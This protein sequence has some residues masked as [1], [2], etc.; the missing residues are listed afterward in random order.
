MK[1]QSIKLSLLKGNSGQIN[2]LPKNPRVIKDDRFAAL[3]KSIQDTPEMLELRELIVFPFA[4]TFVVI[5]GNMRLR[6]L[7]EL[8]Y[9]EAPCKVLTAETPVETLRAI[10]IKDNVAFG[11][12]NFDD[13]ANEWDI[14]ELA[15]W[16]QELPVA[17]TEESEEEK[18]EQEGE[19]VIELTIIFR[20]LKAL[21]ELKKEL[22]ERGFDIKPNK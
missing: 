4:D 20:N 19:E 12:T 17:A 3:V 21:K 16:W 2:G 1:T 15:D 8:G 22:K 7:K 5:A 10:A 6:A 14:T 9:T 11:E 18:D 13:L